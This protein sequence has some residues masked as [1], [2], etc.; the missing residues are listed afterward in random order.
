MRT[1]GRYEVLRTLG[2]GG[3]ATVHLARQPEL[4]RLVALKE[5]HAFHTD[6][7]AILRRFVRES[8][9]AG[10]LSHP[11]IVTVYDF[12]EVDDTPYIAMEYVEAGS[13]RPY[14]PVL[15]DAQ[16][17]FVLHGILA[18]LVHAEEHGVVHRDLKPENVLVSAGGDVKI[19]DFGVAKATRSASTALTGVGMTVGTPGYMAPE[20]AMAQPIGPWTDLYAVGCMAYELFAGAVPFADSEGPM[21]I[22]LRHV[23]EPIPPANGVNPDIDP[24]VSNWIAAL[25]AREPG[26]RTQTAGPALESLEDIAISL[27][28]PRWLRDG[29]LNQ[30]APSQPAPAPAPMPSMVFETYVAPA[31]AV[32]A[33][34]RPAPAPP[35]PEPD[36]FETYVAPALSRPPTGRDEEPPPAAPRRPASP[37]RPRA[38][39]RPTPRATRRGWTTP[40]S[41]R[42]RSCPGAAT[43]AGNRHRTCRRSSRATRRPHHE[44]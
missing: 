20:Q 44:T 15:S 10:S 26:R 33:P 38:T 18:G 5:M 42:T 29:R 24:A 12:L 19:T 37:R 39:R 28:G 16:R 11:N 7:D 36:G 22:L 25:T 27:L 43:T 9:L 41:P 8:R 34:P 14:L 35:P 3:M 31:A 21:A 17:L 6:Q 30:S 23:N 32:A 40:R 2:R 4:D 13:L 1:V